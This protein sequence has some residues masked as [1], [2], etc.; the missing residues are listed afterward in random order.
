MLV[1]SVI[2]PVYNVEP[3]LRQ[4]I[5]SVI[6]QT[7]T[8]LEIILIDDGSTD[9]SGEICDS[10]SD[11]RIKVYHTE[12]HG[13]SAARNLGIDKASGEYI[14]FLDS[15][16]WIDDDFIEQ[17]IRLIGHADI[18]CFNEY[19][20][21]YNSLEA[22]IA[23]INNKISNYAWSKLYRK[24]CFT[25]VRFPDGRI[26][27]D[28]ATAYKFLHNSNLVVCANIHGHHYR[29]R[30][31]SITHTHDLKNIFD[32][33]LAI[34]EKYDYCEAVLAASEKELSEDQIKEAHINLL[35]MRAIAII[36]AWAWRNV[37]DDTESPEWEKLSHEAR[38]QFPI[39]VRRH[40]SWHIRGGLLLARF[41]HPLSFCI[42]HIAHMYTRNRLK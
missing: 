9:S 42:A 17:A 19:E 13:L 8:D 34:F 32:Y 30:E 6:S 28:K 2:V 18:L 38:T 29:D 31:N 11:P 25:T 3:Y 21:V 23:N 4:C 1:V 33:C 36:R 16:D 41:N 5:D 24:E 35:K 39:N 37:N 22:L 14:Y 10:Y 7:Y 27:E 26:V 20:G 12:N 40:F 15:D